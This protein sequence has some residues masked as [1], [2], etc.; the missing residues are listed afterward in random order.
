MNTLLRYYCVNIRSRLDY[1]CEVYGAVSAFLLHKLNVIKNTAIRI[2]FGTL[3]HLP[4]QSSRQNPPYPHCHT[5]SPLCPHLYIK[6]ASSP[7]CHAF[8]SL[9][10]RQSSATLPS[11][12]SF[13]A[14]SSFVERALS[15]FASLGVNPNLFSHSRRLLLWALGF[16][17]LP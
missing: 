1:G 14:Q 3:S 11:L 7:S 10:F 9:L 8:H 16:L 2:A 13:Q 6:L 15:F 12:K 17:S 4:S 5:N